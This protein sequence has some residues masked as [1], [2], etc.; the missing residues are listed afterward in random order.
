MP[1]FLD[2]FAN[3]T[4]LKTLP[5]QITVEKVSLLYNKRDNI[6]RPPHFTFNNRTKLNPL[7]SEVRYEM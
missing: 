2:S 1:V 4:G 7:K 6:H 5:P 3:K